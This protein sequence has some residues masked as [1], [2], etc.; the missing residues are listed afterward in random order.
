MFL[1]DTNV[2]SEIRRGARADQQVQAWAGM[3]SP[4]QVWLSVITIME[5]ELGI[6]R[7]RRRD[8]RQ[9]DLLTQWLE[10]DVIGAHRPR[11]LDVTLAIARRCALLHAPNPR[12]ERDALLAATALTRDLTLVTRN[13]ADFAPM[14]VTLLNPWDQR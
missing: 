3:Q 14:G 12:P 4:H 9:A 6:A 1:L 2:V 8:R 5:L 7:L 10:R 13:V 11:I